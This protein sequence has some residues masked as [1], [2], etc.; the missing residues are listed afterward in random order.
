LR[1]LDEMQRPG[2]T[3]LGAAGQPAAPTPKRTALGAAGAS[4]R[5]PH[6]VQELIQSID[7]GKRSPGDIAALRQAAANRVEGM[8]LPQAQRYL[9]NLQNS[10][11]S[12][13]SLARDAAGIRDSKAASAHAAGQPPSSP[14]SIKEV[15]HELKVNAAD[16]KQVLAFKAELTKY[17]LDKHHTPA[18]AQ[19]FVD[20]LPRSPKVRAHLEELTAKRLAQQ[21]PGAAGADQAPNKP[22]QP[23]KPAPQAQSSGSSINFDN[24]WRVKLPD[25][26]NNV[27]PFKPSADGKVPV[28]AG[29][30]SGPK[31]A[32]NEAGGVPPLTPPSAS[33][34]VKPAAAAGG[35]TE[36]APFQPDSRPVAASA[37]LP[38]ADN[39]ATVPPVDSS[40]LAN[41]TGLPRDTR[42]P[43]PESDQPLA[44]ETQTAA[45]GERFPEDTST[46]D[47]RIKLRRIPGVGDSVTRDAEGRLCI[48]LDP[49]HQWPQ[50]GPI[51]HS[52]V[53]LNAGSV[54][55]ILGSARQ[56]LPNV[57][58]V[59]RGAKIAGA[60]LKGIDLH[61]VDFT[62][63]DL[64]GVDFRGV[65]L[66]GANF[67]SANLDGANL[68]RADLSDANFKDASIEETDFSHAVFNQRTLDSRKP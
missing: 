68:S 58:L 19:Q 51:R 30:P 17:L 7:F 38:P 22:T 43:E 65:D 6:S 14:K 11:D 5:E 23:A 21:P 31:P 61:G 52:S 55:R 56:I 54:R 46:N 34:G 18:Q 8:T 57:G 16:P 60:D 50:V 47:P 49:H 12:Q 40:G 28:T 26:T 67:A 53:P 66:R 45:K 9:R 39:N 4:V 42:T 27:V 48:N 62:G 64:R 2:Q 25:A 32:V 59:L 37:E 24:Q 3:R 10:P 63:A 13:L 36:P 29:S 35:V 1:Q 44:N 33:K 41:T 15:V 20:A